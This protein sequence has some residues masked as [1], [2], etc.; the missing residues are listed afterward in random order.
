MSKYVLAFFASMLL[1][2]WFNM[3]AYAANHDSYTLG[4]FANLTYPFVS[5]IP[6]VMIVEQ[7]TWKDKT[8]IAFFE[9]LGYGIGT[10]IFLAFL[11]E[12]LG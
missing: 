11:K 1:E 9:G 12:R 4:F 5:M 10:I 8:K 6:V 2:F 3:C 7:K